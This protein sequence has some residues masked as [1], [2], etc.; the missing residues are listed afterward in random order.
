MGLNGKVTAKV[1]EITPAKAKKYLGDMVNNRR[2][3]AKHVAF[4]KQQMMS[5][6]WILTNNAIAFNTEGQLMDGQ[7]RLQAVLDS[8]KAFD[9]IV[10]SGLD[11]KA[12]DV[13]DTG[14]VRTAPD[15]LSI[16]GFPYAMEVSAIVRFTM[17]MRTGSYNEAG[18]KGTGQVK[19]TNHQVLEAALQEREKF[20]RLAITAKRWAYESGRLMPPSVWGGLSYFFEIHSR[21]KTEMFMDSLAYGV[22]IKRDSPIHFLR[23][24]L[25]GWKQ[26][27]LRFRQRDQAAITI[28]AWNHYVTGRSM[29]RIT[30]SPKRDGFPEMLNLKKI[31]DAPKSHS[32]G[33]TES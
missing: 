28:M 19:N 5:G 6:D 24:E 16:E 31:L 33:S 8:G 30:W 25:A 21:P 2:L 27:T 1:V 23:R 11:E 17:Q 4:L 9:F 29:K 26:S 3:R 15:I 22:D 7:H 14:K 20:T 10:V 12:F 13:I 18:A 32:S